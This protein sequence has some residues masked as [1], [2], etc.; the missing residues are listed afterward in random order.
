MKDGVRYSI[1]KKIGKENGVIAVQNK[2]IA[3]WKLSKMNERHPKT[4]SNGHVDRWSASTQ[5]C[6]EC[7]SKNKLTLEDRRYTCDCG[8][9][10]K[11]D[12]KA[13]VYY[14]KE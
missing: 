11:R 10:E 6:P 14:G 2:H 9:S 12:R 7:G 3:G 1:K 5:N 13:G 8:Y 4:V